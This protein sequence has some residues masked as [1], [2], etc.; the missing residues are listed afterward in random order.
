M[1]VGAVGMAVG[2]IWEGEVDDFTDG[3]AALGD[4]LGIAVGNDVEGTAVG[5][6]VGA[7][8]GDG[9]GDVVGTDVGLEEGTAVGAWVIHTV[10]SQLP[11]TQSLLAS[12]LCP[13]AHP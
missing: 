2:G 5:T 12:Q 1:T 9:L 8:L 13:G 10:A 4:S 7:A 6:P 11:P 3:T